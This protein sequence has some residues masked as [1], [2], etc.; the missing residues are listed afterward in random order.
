MINESVQ[1][2]LNEQLNKELSSAYLY[3]AMSA[4]FEQ[5]NLF[6]FAKWMKV[7]SGEEL[8]H[9]DK[10]YGFILERGGK[11]DLMTIEK[12][13][14]SWESAMKAFQDAY[15]HEKFITNSIYSVLELSQSQKDYATVEFLQWYVKEQV[16]EEAQ[17]EQIVKKLEMIGD[18]PA[19]LFMLDQELGHRE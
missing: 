13:Q 2:A 6:G 12:P 17:T 10:I 18:T 19:G 4:D 9:A 5:K 11:V 15:E 14:Q 7:Q 8:K 1:K 3:L 16:E